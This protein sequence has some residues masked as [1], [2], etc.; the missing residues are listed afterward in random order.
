MIALHPRPF[1]VAVSGSFVFAL[2][3]VASSI[4]IRWTIDH[5]VIPRFEDGDVAVGTVVT[6]C[7]LIIGIG[8]VRAIGV[9]I[10]RSFAG[11][12]QWRIAE[13][14]SGQVAERLVQQPPSWHQRQ[15]DGQLVAK[16][17]VDVETSVSVM[18]PIP[19][20]TGVVLMIV[21]AGAWLLITDVV[22]GLVAVAV[23]PILILA[24]IGYQHRVERHMDDAQN[25]LGEFSGAVHES[26]E[27]VQL[28]KAYGA[29]QRETDRLSALAG[30]IRDA[31]V[32]AVRIRGMFEAFLEVIP[33]L[34][35]VGLVV[36]GAYRVD[37]GDVTVGELAGFIYMFTLLVFPL[38]LIGH[39]LAD[40]PYS[41]AGW[42]RVRSVVD[43]PLDNDPQRV[44]GRPA[45]SAAVELDHV[46]FMYP[47]DVRVAVDDA[48]ATIQPGLITVIVGSTGSGKSTLVD[49]IGGLIAPTS[50]TVKRADGPV[51]LVFQEAFL[52][53][54][55]V[56]DNVEVGAPL[57]DDSIWEALRLAC[58]DD[59][60][61][62]LPEQ[63]ATVVGERGVSLSGGQRQRVTLARAIA[64][65][66]SL[67]LLD[68]TTSALDPATEL[69]VL[70][71]LR[72]SLTDTAVVIVASRPSTISLADDVIFVIDGRI[73][74]HG[75]HDDLMRD[76]AA[77]RQLVEA[78]ETDRGAVIGKAN[79]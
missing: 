20:A 46:S 12:T 22:M 15:S 52:F 23:F 29:E 2:C 39:A 40:L 55:T 70:S 36:L 75:S 8:I 21:V 18:A 61:A 5:V 24:N 32:R 63:L 54:G 69:A 7:A 4:A 16:A 47:G 51:A 57:D 26:F 78:F 25:A 76:E 31:R 34:T 66:P 50:G 71:N 43:E 42:T 56:R 17:G 45:G 60:V 58:A 27:A 67:L 68:D 77:Y 13:T 30:E 14:L 38:R 41:Q 62:D 3:T 64:R 9:V 19:F 10:R 33:S 74:A 48:T 11:I 79:G 49:L 37:S 53:A 73:A 44:I 65:K 72:A 6:G 59:F 1:I 35:N 28:V